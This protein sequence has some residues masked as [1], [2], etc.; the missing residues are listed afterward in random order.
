MCQDA[1]RL[2]AADGAHG[3]AG[4]ASDGGGVFPFDVA[5]F[6]PAMSVNTVC[7]VPDP[8]ALLREVRR[9]LRPGGML[10]LAFAPRRFMQ[11]LAFAQHGFTLDEADDLLPLLRGAGFA[12]SAPASHAERVPHQEQPGAQVE[13]VFLVWRA[14]GL[15]LAPSM[16]PQRRCAP[17]QWK[18]S[19]QFRAAGVPTQPLPSRDRTVPWPIA[20]A[21]GSARSWPARQ[22]RLRQR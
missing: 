4:F 3:V 11:Q 10:A 17:G 14:G 21:S 12:P 18:V 1:A 22:A 16:R 2:H 19:V 6:D 9:V 7:F 13:R 15:S 5:S 8:L 20:I